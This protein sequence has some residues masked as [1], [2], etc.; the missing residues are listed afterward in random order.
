MSYTIFLAI[1]ILGMDALIYFLF[2]WTYGEKRDA[3][4]R[5]IAAHKNAL[6]QPAPRPFLV[7]SNSAAPAPQQPPSRANN[8]APQTKPRNLAQRL[9]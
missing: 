2:H 5:K 3:L 9:A 7:A 1:C 8:R 6:D 4:A